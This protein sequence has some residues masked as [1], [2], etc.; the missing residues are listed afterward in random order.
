MWGSILAP[1]ILALGARRGDQFATAAKSLRRV[2]EKL[3]F[4]RLRRNADSDFGREHRFDEIHSVSDFQ[5]NVGLSDYEAMLP[6]IRR[7]LE[8]DEGALFGPQEH[9][10]LFALT[11]GTTRRSKHLPVTERFIREYRLGWWVWGHHAEKDHPRAFDRHVLQLTSPACEHRTALG[12]PCGSVSGLIAQMQPSFVRRMY[13]F[14]SAASHI[15]DGRTKYYVAMRFAATRDLSMISTANPSTILSAVRVGM[16]DH[17]A[18][19]RDVRDGTISFPVEPD[20]EIARA[21]RERV[22]PDPE[23]ARRLEEILART[24]ALAP[25]EMWPNLGL[26]ACWKGGTLQNYVA[27]LE[28]C[29]PGVPVRDIGLLASEG[30]MTI[31]LSARG[32]AGVLDLTSH[33]YEFIPIEEADADAPRTLL[34]QELEVGR[35]YV[36]VLTTS[37]G[38]YRYNIN[39]VVRVVDRY[40]SAPVLEFLNK[41]TGFSSI[42]GEKLSEFQAVCAVRQACGDGRY[43]IATFTMF[44]RWGDPPHYSILVEEGALAGVSEEA[45]VERLDKVLCELNMEYESKRHTGRLGPVTLDRVAD[46]TWDRYRSWKIEN[47]RGRLEQYKH[48]YLEQDFEYRKKL[49]GL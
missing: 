40:H 22:R 24:G 1:V 19:I 25:R 9:V 41:G 27:Q 45:F 8:G 44:P 33:F 47:N 4:Q 14:P 39:D 42:T 26:V 30:R 6:Y 21:L 31:P 15:K 49:D 7:V 13:V 23:G 5:R 29:F 43:P 32:S 3:L 18:L 48:V 20:R 17:E 37:G 2:Q 10:K 16:E 28:G 46:G 38:L 35:S 12:L 11:S 36:L 34:A